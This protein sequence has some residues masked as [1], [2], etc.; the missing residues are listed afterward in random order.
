MG[1]GVCV[2]AG[3]L[4]VYLLDCLVSSDS[5]SFPICE[6]ITYNVDPSYLLNK[7]M[8]KLYGMIEHALR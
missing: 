1:V 2:G 4:A 6:G 7:C 8:Y 3:V 5:Y